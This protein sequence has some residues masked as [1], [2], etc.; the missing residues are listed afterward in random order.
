M[1]IWNKVLLVL[2]L[3]LGVF[4]S[5]WSAKALKI[6]SEWAKK[7]AKL[8]D[9][10]VNDLK[11]IDTLNDI[12]KGVPSIP[13]L[14]ALE[15]KYLV[16]NA[17]KWNGCKPLNVASSE[18]DA[19][20]ISVQFELE[21]KTDSGMKVG[22]VIYLFDNRPIEEGG[23]FLGR[24]S[25]TQIYPNG[26]AVADSVDLLEDSEKMAVQQSLQSGATWTAHSKCPADRPD[27]FNTLSETERQKF[28]VLARIPNYLNEGYEPV[29]FGYLLTSLNENRIANQE[30]LA[31]ALNRKKILEEV[32]VSVNQ[33]RLEL[34]NTKDGIE[35][36]IKQMELQRDEL[37][38]LS[39][40]LDKEIA[41]MKKQIDTVQ[42]QN[43]KLVDDLLKLQMQAVSKN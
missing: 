28:P 25:V 19:W 39:N 22:D 12:S 43:E 35:K 36:R 2:I 14:E 16:D 20:K 29:D 34:Q 40:S 32:N 30:T 26:T 6:N 9:D 7:V 18:N 15:F 11:K 3:L 37:K 33:Q 24:F 41:Q 17:E 8:E 31:A 42:S 21:N 13:A 10:K 5:M 27:F 38:K 4:A 23:R 1:N